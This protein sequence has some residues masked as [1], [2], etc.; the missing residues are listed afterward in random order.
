[1]PYE[2]KNTIQS[3]SEMLATAQERRL[4]SRIYNRTADNGEVVSAI[5][6][7][8]AEDLVDIPQKA[9]LRNT[10]LIKRIVIAYAAMCAKAG[11]IPSK[12]GLAR[13][14]GYSRRAL[15]YFCDK[16]PEHPTAELLELAYDAFAEA[17]TTA[18]LANA[19]NNVFSIFISKAL[20]R[21]EDTVTIKATPPDPMDHRAT[22][23]EIMAR[24]SKEELDMLPA[25]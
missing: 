4:N 7:Q 21:F 1:M 5:V 9:D 18:A 17:L 24:Y 20:Y 23:A 2:P 12:I 19:T 15:E 14:C 6:E 22:A 13:A 3:P 8:L 11:T 25:D 16:H 10:E